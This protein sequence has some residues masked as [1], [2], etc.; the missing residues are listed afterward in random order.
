MGLDPASDP[1]AEVFR[2]APLGR[3]VKRRPSREVRA[4]AHAI[5][6]AVRAAD[7]RNATVDQLLPL[8]REYPQSEELQKIVARLLTELNDERALEAW[9]GISMRFP[10]SMDAFRNL[11]DLVLRSKGKAA[12]RTIVRA[13]F[14]R[15]PARLDQLLAYAEACDAIGQTDDSGAA[16]GLVAR[17]F[18]KRKE[19]WL[20]FAAWLEEEIGMH[21]S[22]V[23]L[24]RRIA[25]GAWLGPPLLQEDKRLHAVISD[26]EHVD[27]VALNGSSLASVRV[28]EALFDR[29]L[30]DRRRALSA[31]APTSGKLVLLTGSLGAGG[32]ERQFVTTAVGLRAMSLQQRTLPDGLVLDEVHVVA[33]SLVDREDGSFYVADLQR[34]GIQVESYRE[35]PD[36]G[37]DLASSVARPT[38]RALGF[39]PWSTAEAVIKLSDRLKEMKP[40]VVHI[41]QDGLVYAAGLAALLAGVPRIVL[42]GRSTPP[43]DRRE[44]YLVEYDV[45]YKSLLQAPGVVLS[46]NSRHAA[47]RYA[48]WLDIDERA[49]VVMPNGVAPLSIEAGSASPAMFSTFEARTGQ[50]A[51][52]I[53]SVMRLDE[54]KRPL[55]WVDAAAAILVRVPTM[56]FIVVGDGPYRKRMLRRAT[57]LGVASRCLFVGR[58]ADVGYWLSKMDLLML[59][60]EHEGLP[61]ALIEAQL[62]GVPVIASAAG[63]TAETVIPGKTG[64][65]TSVKATPDEIANK[66]AALAGEPDRLKNMA[67][68][69][70]TWAMQ[71]FPI[72]RM[73]SNTL[74]LYAAAGVTSE[75]HVT[76]GES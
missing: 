61:N 48:N 36:F 68:E 59:L 76:R 39:L 35:W 10:A 55:L 3:V 56:R 64:L 57:K 66:I 52:T 43:P 75:P 33:R 38:L 45:I 44:N 62:A 53:G 42:S 31:P 71:A 41:W 49:I 74:N 7:C 24:L 65:V 70:R 15:M 73:L 21:R 51:M 22:V 27:A 69:A 1:L 67:S 29:I 4:Q 9:L 17:A 13:R 60:S 47:G 25:A 46:V 18:S 6:D 50:G 40:A 34:A 8:V 37:G 63:G 58:T 5:R 12:V 26:F 20:L 72:P 14:P 32:A 30:D 2:P 28:L 54:V 23:T 19:A 16:F 11:V